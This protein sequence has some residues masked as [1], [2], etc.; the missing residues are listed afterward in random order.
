M[1]S[2]KMLGYA[3]VLADMEAKRAA[4]DAAITALRT[5]LTLGAL[6]Q[7]GDAEAAALMTPGGAGGLGGSPVELPHGALLGKS[8]PAA[9]K[10]YLSAVKRKQ[11][12]REITTALREG[13]VESTS[14]NFENIVTGALHRLRGAGD[15]LRFKDGWALDI[16][17]LLEATE[18]KA[19]A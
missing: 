3:E 13:G 15:V 14:S 9:I 1:A 2:E 17:S 6:G 7:P 16:V 5:A 12:V 19:A 11:T 4:L 8:L 10:L 18:N